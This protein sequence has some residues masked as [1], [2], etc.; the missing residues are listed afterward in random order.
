MRLNRIN[1]LAA[2]CHFSIFNGSFL[3]QRAKPSQ[4]IALFITLLGK[5]VDSKGLY[6]SWRLHLM[7]SWLSVDPW[8]YDNSRKKNQKLTLFRQRL[9]QGV[10]GDRGFY[11]L[12]SFGLLKYFIG[13]G[14]GAKTFRIA[15]WF[16]IPKY[17]FKVSLMKVLNNIARLIKEHITKIE[18]TN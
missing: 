10:I 11:L 17:M 13:G 4:G 3:Y 7:G 14:G 5:R 2:C 15:K 6:G 16:S 12:L 1:A 9:T 8:S 18:R